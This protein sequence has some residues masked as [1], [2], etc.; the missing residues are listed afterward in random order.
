MVALSFAATGCRSIAWQ[1]PIPKSVA[2]SRQFSQQGMSAMERG[3]WARAE[4]LFSRAVESCPVDSE[5]RRN[6]AETL[7][8]RGAVNEA[9]TQLEAAR[10]E[11][12]DDT[13]LAVRT[14]ELYLSMGK[15]DQA[16]KLAEQTLDLDPKMADAWVLRGRTEEAIGQTREAL[17][18]YQRSLGYNPG[19]VD[20]LFRVAEAY[21]QLRQPERTLTVLQ[22]LSDSFPPG[23]EPQRL[24]HLE[25]MA[26]LTLGRY[27]DAVQSLSLARQRGKPS[28]EILC[29]LAEAELLAGR[30][31]Q[32]S[33][34]VVQALALEPNHVASR[35]L[36][37]RI[38]T[39]RTGRLTNFTR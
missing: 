39:A 2:T 17:A 14:G 15:I 38:E 24:L 21:Q 9:A 27:N 5:A 12:A 35:A 28:A 32:A 31:V 13:S 36:K 7:W 33:T 26:L 16:R 10:R 23:E 34:T 3:D 8:H 1:G 4:A 22:N 37:D 20:V 30:Q 19:N 18:D 6:Y 29:R 25:G 11:A